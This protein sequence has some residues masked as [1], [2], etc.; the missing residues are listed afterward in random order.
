MERELFV[1][2][3]L[4]GRAPQAELPFDVPGRALH[5]RGLLR[6]WDRLA[7]EVAALL[8]VKPVE[9]QEPG[10]VFGHARRERALLQRLPE[11][12]AGLVEPQLLC[13]LLAS[14]ERRVAAGRRGSEAEPTEAQDG[15]E[16]ADHV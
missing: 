5:G 15:D 3:R 6:G 14:L 4:V 7:E 12:V 16:G 8:V 2:F 13:S 9:V 1:L 10:H 11:E